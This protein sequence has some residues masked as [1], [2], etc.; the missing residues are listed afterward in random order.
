MYVIGV[1]SPEAPKPFQYNELPDGGADVWIRD[2]VTE[3]KDAE[4]NVLYTYN[5]A[6]FKTDET[7]ESIREDLE[8]WT[9]YAKEWTPEVE[10]PIPE[11]VEVLEAKVDYLMIMEGL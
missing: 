5:E 4:D 9:E 6:Y 11:R 3:G 1:E 8:A 2:N 10:R 7:E